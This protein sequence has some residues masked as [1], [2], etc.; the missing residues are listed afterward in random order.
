MSPLQSALR[1]KLPFTI[2][3]DTPVVP[4]EP[5]RAIWS[6]VNRV[7]TSGKVLGPDQCIDV[8][9]AIRAYTYN[10]AYQ[11]FLEDKTGSIEPGKWADLILLDRDP[12]SCPPMELK[13]IEVVETIVGGK[14]I[15]HK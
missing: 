3:C 12:L 11:Y 9:S 10:A 14:S 4:Q 6:A 1:R 15:Y 13:D 8:Q 5:F 7:S 2:H